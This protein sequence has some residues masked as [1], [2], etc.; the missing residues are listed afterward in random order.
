MLF[1]ELLIIAKV[2]FM[3][4]SNLYEN[5]QCSDHML[6]DNHSVSASDNSD[7]CVINLS[8]T[9]K[10][11]HMDSKNE[12]VTIEACCSGYNANINVE[13]TKKKRTGQFGEMIDKKK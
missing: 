4:P 2:I 13:C 5:I 3:T 11:I 12:E 1:Y 6:N 9:D 10:N 8:N 7:F